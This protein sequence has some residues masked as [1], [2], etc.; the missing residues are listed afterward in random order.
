VRIPSSVV[1]VA[2]ALGVVTIVGC[3]LDSAG[4]AIVPG[5]V[6]DAGGDLD[7]TDPPLGTMVTDATTGADANLEDATAAPDAGGSTTPDAGGGPS[8]DAATC[9]GVAEVCNDGVDNDCNGKIDCAD[10]A[11]S[12]GFV[13]APAAPAGWSLVAYAS[14]ARTSCGAGFGSA[15]DLVEGPSA[16]PAT[17]A[18][19]CTVDPVDQGSCEKGTA[20]L[21]SNGALGGCVALGSLDFP[22]ADGACGSKKLDSVVNS[23]AQIAPLPYTPGKC[24]PAP[25]KT[26][27]PVTYAAQG[28]SCLPAVALGGGC[29]AGACAA[30]PAAPF[31]MCVAKAGDQPCPAGFP[32]KHLAGT[33]TTDTRD[34]SACGCSTTGS[35]GNAKLTL[36]EDSS[37]DPTSGKAILP[38]VA[39]DKCDPANETKATT[40][41]AY[42]YSADLLNVACAPTASVASG[43]VSLVGA[44]TV[45]CP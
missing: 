15:E 20:K 12:V 44:R 45:C 41:Q 6:M 30:R 25:S 9:S 18:C 24:A 19:G 40:Y 37:C 39:D 1:V 21:Y 43:A 28:R 42:V 27:T 5:E 7:V 32:Q 3:G 33:G 13:C 35:C 31:G 26:V 4:D 14:A 17:C 22:A 34:C 36:Y 8:H 10:P 29:A 2:A 23:K 16:L 11:C 38:L